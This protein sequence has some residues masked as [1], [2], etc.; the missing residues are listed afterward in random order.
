MYEVLNG[1]CVMYCT[2]VLLTAHKAWF[3]RQRCSDPFAS[4]LQITKLHAATTAAAGTAADRPLSASRG[5]GDA[6]AAAAGPSAAAAAAAAATPGALPGAGG[7]VARLA[8]GAASAAALDWEYYSAADVFGA[9][10]MGA[11]VHEAMEEDE[12]EDDEGGEVDEGAILQ[13]GVLGGGVELSVGPP[14]VCCVYTCVS[15]SRLLCVGSWQGRQR[16]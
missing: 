10:A 11:G 5:S 15:L 7:I 12:D 4:T 9:E 13:V 2:Q 6:D 16:H 14:A 3:V 8:A 1:A